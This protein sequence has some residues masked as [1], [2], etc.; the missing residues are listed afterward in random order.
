MDHHNNPKSDRPILI[1]DDEAEIREMIASYLKKEGFEVVG[2]KD[3]MEGKKALKQHEPDVILLDWNMPQGEGIDLVK[4]LRRDPAY[5]DRYI[6]MVTARSES[7][8][9]LEGLDAGA[10]DYITKPFQVSDLLARVRVGVRTR[11]LQRKLAQQ[12]KMNTVLQMAGAIA[13]EIGNPL[14]AIRLIHHNLLQKPALST[15]PS[16]AEDLKNLAI[17]LD[18]IETLVRE[19][20]NVTSLHSI[21]Y[22]GDLRITNLRDMTE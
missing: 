16:L 20:Q 4:D 13:H 11:K 17:A 21:P 5:N 3:V 15:D 6:I 10:D 19:A 9:L 22:A 2:A 7:E 18:R 8:E 1:V 12:V 14:T